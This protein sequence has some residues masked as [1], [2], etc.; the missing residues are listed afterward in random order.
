FALTA[1]RL[2]VRGIE[3]LPEGPC[4]LVANHASY[5]DGIVL[6]AALPRPF[7][8]VAKIELLRSFVTRVGLTRL[9]AAFVERFDAPQGVAAAARLVEAVAQG[10]SLIVF[11]EGTFTAAAGRLP[12]HMGAF[13]VAVRAG[14]PVVPVTL[15]GTR[16]LL[17]DGRWRPRRAALGLQFHPP[18]ADAADDG[19][20]FGAAVRLRD[21]ARRAIGPEAAA[22]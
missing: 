1:T 2:S 22:G 5:L 19:Q 12:F 18:L 14:V 9:G 6:T 4:V 15:R 17:P 16:D 20:V 13:L 11:P 3:Q 8:F 10:Q 21:A 7:T